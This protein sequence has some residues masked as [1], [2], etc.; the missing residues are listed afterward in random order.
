[1]GCRGLDFYLYNVDP[2]LEPDNLVHYIIDNYSHVG[3]KGF[4]LVGIGAMCMSN[5]DANLNSAAVVL[6]HDFLNP[7]NIK[8]KSEL[9]LTKGIALIIGLVAVFLASLDYDLLS[10]VFMT[11]SY[12]L[13]TIP[14]ILA[15]LGFRTTEK[16]VLIAM[17]ANFI[18]VLI[19]RTWFMDITEIDSMVPGDIA[20]LVSLIGGHY[21]LKQRGGWVGAKS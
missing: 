12:N 6:T 10:L 16:V 13:V 7:L 11:Q 19:W 3:L 8:L 15:I 4:I 17:G 21:L 14:L 20:S 5:A 1:M 18:C 2:N 9:M